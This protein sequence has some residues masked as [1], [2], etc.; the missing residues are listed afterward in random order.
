[1]VISSLIL[2]YIL[3]Q[4]H[5]LV[6]KPPDLYASFLY[7]INFKSLFHTLTPSHPHSFTPSLF[8]TL[9]FHTLTLSHPHSFTLSLFHTI[10]L[11][12]LHSFTPSPFHSL[13]P[14]L[15]VIQNIITALT[16]ITIFLHEFE[17]ALHH[18]FYQS[19]HIIFGYPS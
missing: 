17:V 5:T 11:S 9:T 7:L 10:T 18:I 12:H 14:S 19:L 16:Q 4:I 6:S 13:T 1:M 15:K 8:H 2:V 3:H